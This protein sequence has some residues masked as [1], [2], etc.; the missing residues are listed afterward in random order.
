MCLVTSTEMQQKSNENKENIKMPK[1][2]KNDFM[3][4]I[5]QQEPHPCESRLHLFAIFQAEAK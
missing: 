3:W 2:K 4:E 1:K 5:L